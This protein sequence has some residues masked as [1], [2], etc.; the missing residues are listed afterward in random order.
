MLSSSLSCTSVSTTEDMANKTGKALHES[1]RVH[2]HEKGDR[3]DDQFWFLIP[4][5]S[6]LCLTNLYLSPKEDVSLSV[7]YAHNPA[8]DPSH[9]KYDPLLWFLLAADV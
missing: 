8:S 6:H 4:T 1:P 3:N 2:Q 9:W 7:S 5:H